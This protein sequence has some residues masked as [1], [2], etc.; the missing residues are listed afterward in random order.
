MKDLI[1][2]PNM[3]SPV[4]RIINH[5]CSQEC[6]KSIEQEFLHN[7][8]I[9]WKLKIKII[10]HVGNPYDWAEEKWMMNIW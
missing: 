4:I 9:H 6:L 1:P 8:F 10:S 3:N 2:H 5:A 7:G